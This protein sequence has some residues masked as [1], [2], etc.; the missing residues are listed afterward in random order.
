M[1]YA[2]AATKEAHLYTVGQCARILNVSAKTLR[3]YDAIHLFVP[4]Q[5][6]G[7][8]QYRYY[9][10]HQL[11]LLRRIV[12]LRGLGLGLEVIR[13]LLRAGTLEDPVR[14]QAI[15]HEHAAR[16]RCEIDAQREQLDDI[17]R[18][19]ALLTHDSHDTH[20]VNDVAV[21]APRGVVVKRVPE[22]RAVAVRRSI[23]L[24][25]LD[26]L[27]HEAESRLSGPPTG[28]PVCVYYNPEFDP[29]YVDVEVLF[30]AHGP[31]ERILPAV[32][33]ATILQV[34]LESVVEI[35]AA[36]GALYDWIEEHET[37]DAG[38]PREVVLVGRGSGKP[39]AEHVMEIQVPIESV[40]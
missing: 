33:V 38:P 30:P 29:E 27:L 20:N 16:I 23:H 32:T 34:G 4:A 8:N 25:D 36:Y 6:G 1:P 22:I 26:A 31:G 17:E 13:D 21:S 15:L 5:I 11:P 7:G 24:R 10:Q 40:K 14:L 39:R 9:G 3:Y 35:G 37:R 18:A 19:I 28:P 12:F 2:E